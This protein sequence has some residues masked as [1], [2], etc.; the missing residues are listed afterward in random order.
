MTEP[1]LCSSRGG[2]AAL[3]L[4]ASEGADD[5]ADAGNTLLVAKHPLVISALPLC[6]ETTPPARAALRWALVDDDND[7]RKPCWGDPAAALDSSALAPRIQATGH[8]LTLCLP[9]QHRPGELSTRKDTPCS[10]AWLLTT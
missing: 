8:A 3:G 1:V 4:S 6:P 2:S 10:P 9:G 7:N 5:S